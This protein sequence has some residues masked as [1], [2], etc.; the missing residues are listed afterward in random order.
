M[1]NKTDNPVKNYTVSLDP[2]IVAKAKSKNES[3]GGKLS[4]TINRLLKVWLHFPEEIKNLFIKVKEKE[5]Q[6]S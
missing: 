1:V 6:E 5:D 4:P 2:V 3:E